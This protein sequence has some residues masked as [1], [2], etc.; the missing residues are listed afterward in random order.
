M[1]ALVMLGGMQG[2][3][4][5][6]P[7][8]SSGHLIFL[9]WL[10]GV[11]SPGAALEVSLHLGTLV[12]VVWVYRHWIGKWLRGLIQGERQ[13]YRMLGCLVVASLP[14]GGVGL[15][16]GRWLEGYFTIGAVIMGWLGT[17]L[18]LWLM[19]YFSVDVAASATSLTLSQ[20]WWIG[21]AQALALWPGL[22][23]SGST[24]AMARVVGV[25]G[26]EAAQFSFLLAIPAVVGASLFEAPSLVATHISWT[27][28]GLGALIAAVT[29]VIAIQWITRIVNRPQ[30]WRGFAVYVWGL[31]VLAW[32]LGG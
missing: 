30:A 13:A 29:G 16:A 20:A 22:S 11:R 21:C 23:R 25:K 12:A 26:D 6:L 7:V 27:R 8:S 10:F 28:W 15:L 2:L 1:W 5:F 32:S 17:G 24:I 3:T 9:R 14:A 18:L 31:A 19:P 4:E